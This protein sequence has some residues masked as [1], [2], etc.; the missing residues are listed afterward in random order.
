MTAPPGETGKA[1]R[2]AH[3]IIDVRSPGEYQ[4]GAV[5]GAVN[6]SLF[7]DDERAEIGTLYKTLGRSHAVAAGSEWLGD[8]LEAF[9][10]QFSPFQKSDLLVYC[11][12][13]GMRS[14]AVVALLA[15]RGFSVHQ[16]PSGYK[17][18]R[19]HLLSSFNGPMPEHLM[20]L[21]GQT[22]VSKTQLLGLLPNAL[23]L[24]GIAQHRSSVFG[25]INLQPRTQQWFDSILYQTF[26]S[27]DWTAPL[28]VEGE[29][30]KVGDVYLPQTLYNA[31]KNGTLIKLHA[32]F[33]TRVARIVAEYGKADP[34]TIA[35]WE[36]ALISLRPHLGGARCDD[37]IKQVQ[38]AD[39]TPPV[40][41]LLQ[42]Y[43][44]PRY[45]HTMRD[46][47]FDLELSSE[48]LEEAAQTLAAFAA[49]HAQ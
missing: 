13:G 22:G 11:A 3:T 14:K 43:Y 38:K 45:A 28:W 35:Q 32:S 44:D 40:E 36:R 37:M 33:A 47:H 48:N 49:A 42:E 30:R 6:I 1:I 5:A 41:V 24:E 39:F 23:D 12:R 21:H 27:L 29:S 20:V 46:Y 31:M 15:E 10:A 8:R 19:N 7:S 25:A 17:A 18:F 4:H 26:F 34:Q 16:L 2:A 9:F